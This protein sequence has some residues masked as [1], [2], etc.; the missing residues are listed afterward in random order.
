MP[1]GRRGLS[2]GLGPLSP[3]PSAAQVSPW[4]PHLQPVC[5][6]V[7]TLRPH[8]C[9]ATL[10]PDPGS[11]LPAGSLT[12]VFVRLPCGGVGVSVSLMCK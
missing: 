2:L 9:P 10:P 3:G 5:P 6:S 12:S 7:D 8:Q 11:L 1:W 4:Q